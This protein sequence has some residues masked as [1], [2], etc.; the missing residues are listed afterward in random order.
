MKN[1]A[2]YFTIPVM[3]LLVALQ[4]A[5]FSYLLVV[6]GVT[7]QLIP[8]FVV[9]WALW[10][11]S[12]ETMIGAFVG[13]LLIDLL[14]VTPLGVSACALLL[15]LAVIMPIQG[16]W[17]TNRFLAPLLLSFVSIFIFQLAHYALLGLVGYHFSQEVLVFF[18]PSLIIHSLLVIPIYWLMIGL[19]GAFG[20]KS[21]LYY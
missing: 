12:A 11:G 7:I 2:I 10:Q 21:E 4:S 6:G 3:M 9:A 20:R 8:I 1:W 14:S 16:N 5:F 19:M 13:G 15:A 17:R 18:I